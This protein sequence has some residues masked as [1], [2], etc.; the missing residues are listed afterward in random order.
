MKTIRL[1][2]MNW[3]D[4]KEALEK[5]FTYKGGFRKRIYDRSCRNWFH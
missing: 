3:P 4:I 5:G 2:D 1:E